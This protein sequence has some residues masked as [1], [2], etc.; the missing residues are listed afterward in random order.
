MSLKSK[1]KNKELTVGTW[2]SLAH[3]AIAEIMVKAGFDWVTIDLEHSVITIR[4]AEEMIRV[5]DLGGS[6]PLVRLSS[7]DPVQIKRMMD[8]GARGI[9]VPMVNSR[10]DVNRAVKAVHYPEKGTRGV[11]LARAQGYGVNFQ[12]NLNWLKCEAV[13]IVQIE[14]ITAVENIEAILSCDNVDGFIIGP[15][16]LSASMGLPGQFDHPDL[17]AAL[18][19]IREVGEALKK[20]GGLHI[21]E[22]NP[23]ELK[24][25]IEEGFNFLAYSVDFRMLDVSCR[26]G[27][28]V[29]DQL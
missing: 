16:D 9:I 17:V 24:L 15:Y 28:Q 18:K 13:I 11:G 10:E 2:L 25:R 5:I 29:R 23:Q 6:V 22:P 3:P 20:S 27:L 19:K 12:E 1:L 4:E 26:T 8:A 14:H 7:N 21:V